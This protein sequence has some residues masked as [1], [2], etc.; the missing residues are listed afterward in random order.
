MKLPLAPSLA[1]RLHRLALAGA[2]VAIPLAVLAHGTAGEP[3]GPLPPA[4]CPAAAH[5]A[6]PG[7]PPFALP[8]PPHLRHLDLTEAQQDRAFAL[9]HGQAPAEREA[10]KAACRAAGELQR[11]VAAD[12]FDVDKARSLAQ[13]HADALA[14]L[15]LLHAEL[16]ARL[17]GLLTPEQR[18]RLDERRP[19]GPAAPCAAGQP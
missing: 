17:R 1:T 8:L 4:P 15:T 16:E 18:K 10:A 6:P 14:R 13:A 19:A 12:A 3:S 2:V 5:G 7:L 9:F 11:L